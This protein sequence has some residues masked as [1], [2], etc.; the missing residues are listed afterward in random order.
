M[1]D[2][3]VIKHTTSHNFAAVQS[4]KANK[5]PFFSLPF[6]FFSLW[7]YVVCVCTHVL[8]LSLFKGP[9]KLKSKH[10]MR[11]KRN[12]AFWSWLSPSNRLWPVTSV[13]LFQTPC[14][15]R[16]LLSGSSPYLHIS[17]FYE[18][19]FFLCVCLWSKTHFFHL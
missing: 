3:S 16:S 9:S 7:V 8:K 14:S 6:F 18:H 12:S 19:P 11:R 10:S 17:L 1:Y 5:I 15:S 4:E 13:Y 2:I